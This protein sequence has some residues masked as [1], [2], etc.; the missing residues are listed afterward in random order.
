M[1]GTPKISSHITDYIVIICKCFLYCLFEKMN[2]SF[3]NLNGRMTNDVNAIYIQVKKYMLFANRF[4][5]YLEKDSKHYLRFQ[6][7]SDTL[8]LYNF[9]H[10]ILRKMALSK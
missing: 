1:L 7:H 10:L 5:E 8:T 9:M 4:L 6:M 2:L 3:I